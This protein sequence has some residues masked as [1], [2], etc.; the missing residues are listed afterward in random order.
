[1][2]YFL[3]HRNNLYYDSG[4][5]GISTILQLYR[6]GCIIIPYSYIVSGVLLYLTVISCRVY[7][8]TLQ[9]YRG[10]CIIIPYI[11]CNYM[12]IKVIRQFG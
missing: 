3:V 10:G 1:M 2:V 4:G 7:Y 12:F 6:G 5:Y 9:L 11:F 8:Y